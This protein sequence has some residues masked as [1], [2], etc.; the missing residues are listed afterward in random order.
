MVS[1]GDPSGCVR[2]EPAAVAELRVVGEPAAGTVFRLR[3]GEID[4]G[5]PAP[6]VT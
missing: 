3:F 4:I 1:I 6:V 2:P 5:G